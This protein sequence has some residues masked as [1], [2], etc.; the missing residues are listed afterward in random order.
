[1]ERLSDKQ[2]YYVHRMGVRTDQSCLYNS[3]PDSLLYQE[4]LSFK[5]S[6]ASSNNVI[7]EGGGLDDDSDWEILPEVNYY[8]GGSE[9]SASPSPPPFYSGE[10]SYKRSP[11]ILDTSKRS[12]QYDSSDPD[13]DSDSCMD[14]RI[15]IQGNTAV[16]HSDDEIEI[17]FHSRGGN[18]NLTA[19]REPVGQLPTPPGYKASQDDATIVTGVKGEYPDH[20]GNGGTRHHRRRG[21]DKR[22]KMKA[23]TSLPPIKTTPTSFSTS[24]RITSSSC[25]NNLVLSRHLVADGPDGSTTGYF[26][27]RR[28]EEEID[29]IPPSSSDDEETDNATSSPGQPRR[30]V[31]RPL[32]RYNFETPLLHVPPLSGS[33]SSLEFNSPAP[34]SDV[35]ASPS[36][37]GGGGFKNNK[38][39]EEEVDGLFTGRPLGLSTT[40]G[41]MQTSR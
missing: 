32:W 13:E 8:D 35:K 33:S 23:D 7:T 3:S 38:A 17:G 39:K 30:R 15:R 11:Y 21:S 34:T 36:E 40:A 37:V 25:P 28:I 20:H 6:Q 5:A 2:S 14:G 19:L 22:K 41:L 1:M 18:L 26:P 4:M 29:I 27:S 24:S 12:M 10:N 9:S 31:Q 16:Q